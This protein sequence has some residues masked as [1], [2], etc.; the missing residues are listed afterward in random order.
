MSRKAIE[1]PA[2]GP[3]AFTK[4]LLKNQPLKTAHTLYLISNFNQC[5]TVRTVNFLIPNQPFV[6]VGV[7]G[8]LVRQLKAGSAALNLNYPA[9]GLSSKAS[10][11][12]SAVEDVFTNKRNRSHE[13]QRLSSLRFA[14]MHLGS[15]RRDCARGG[16]HIG[17]RPQPTAIIAWNAVFD[18]FRRSIFHISN[19]DL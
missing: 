2:W 16:D 13:S 17:H 6:G 11:R 19:I 7:Y 12:P 8:T 1:N 3:G 10:G 14:Y 4:M 18:V 15:V 5:Y 9:N